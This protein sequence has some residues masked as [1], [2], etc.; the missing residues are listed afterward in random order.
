MAAQRRKA[1]AL[2]RRMVV[3]FYIILDGGGEQKFREQLRQTRQLPVALGGVGVVRLK[4]LHVLAL[5][6]QVRFQLRHGDAQRF[7]QAQHARLRHVFLR[8]VIH[9]LCHVAV[10]VLIAVVERGLAVH[11][12]IKPQRRLQRHLRPVYD[13]VLHS[14]VHIRAVY[15]YVIAHERQRAQRLRYAVIYP[16]RRGHGVYPALRRS[17]ER[18]EVFL[19]HGLCRVEKR[20][21]QIKSYQLAVQVFSLPVVSHMIM[22]QIRRF[23]K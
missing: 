5:F 4:L 14:V 19:R 17:G 11:V 6:A 8:P 23:G 2:A 1:V 7:Q 21:V 18:G 13:R 22:P 9:R 10:P 3:D 12:F 16:P 20:S 15:A